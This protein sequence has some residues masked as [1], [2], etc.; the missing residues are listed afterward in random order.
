MLVHP[1]NAYSPKVLSFEGNEIV[2]S[3]AQF[4]K[5]RS[6]I[7]VIPSG[8]LT[9]SSDVQPQNEYSPNAVKVEGL[10]TDL[11]LQFLKAEEEM[12]LTPSLIT[13]APVP[14]SQLEERA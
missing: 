6:G 3:E 8:M 1:E 13:T 4:W 9:V 7:V 11:I 5:Q 2:E 14:Y 12:V 10:F